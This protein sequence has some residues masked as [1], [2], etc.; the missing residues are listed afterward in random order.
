MLDYF[1]EK[2]KT[3]SYSSRLNAEAESLEFALRELNKMTLGTKVPGESYQWRHDG[4]YKSFKVDFKRKP[5]NRIN[6][7]IKSI[8]AQ[9]SYEMGELTH[10]VAFSVNIE[11][12]LQIGD[13]LKF[14]CHK[15]YTVP[16]AIKNSQNMGNYSLLKA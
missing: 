14:K 3:G 11:R 15:I 9:E 10:I 6:I 16:E 4:I 2:C 1:G 13:E 12:A 8:Q 5:S 7:C